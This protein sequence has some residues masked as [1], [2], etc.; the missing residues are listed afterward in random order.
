GPRGS[1][2]R[3]PG[4]RVAGDRSEAA[5]L[6]R[7]QGTGGVFRIDREP[8]FRHATRPEQRKAPRHEC[9]RQTPPAPRTAHADVLDPAA[10]PPKPPVLLRVDVAPDLAGD[11]IASPRDPPE[12]GV[13]LG[14]IVNEGLVVLLARVA[15]PPVIAESLL[16]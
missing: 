2:E 6:V 13:A 9:T 15:A 5:A 8:P 12:R 4:C 16:A 10:P 3:L 11:L 1:E 14:L 7:S